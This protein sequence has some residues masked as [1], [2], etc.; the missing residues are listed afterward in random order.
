[1]KPARCL[2]IEMLAHAATK[3]PPECEFLMVV[4][5]GERER[6]GAN[7]MSKQHRDGFRCLTSVLGLV[8]EHT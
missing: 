5:G 4:R 1:M 8:A 2:E 6:R 3:E 7:K